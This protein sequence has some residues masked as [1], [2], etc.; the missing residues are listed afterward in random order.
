MQ[1]DLYTRSTYARVYTV[2]D[3]LNELL[4]HGLAVE[5]KHYS[6]VLKG[7]ICDAPAKAMIKC[8]KQFSG[9]YACDCCYQKCIWLHKVTYQEVTT[10]HLR[11]DHEFCIQAQ[12]QHHH[13]I[14]PFCRLP[15][16]MIKIFPNDY[17]HQSCLRLYEKAFTYLDERSKKNNRM[18]AQHVAQISSK[19]IQLRSSI[20]TAFAHQPKDLESVD[21]WRAT[22][23]RQFLL[24][25]GKIVLKKILKQDLYEH[26]M[27]FSVALA[28][29]VCP[30]L[31]KIYKN[32]AKEL[33]QYFVLQAENFMDQNF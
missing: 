15:V 1:I 26:F 17:M 8:I 25:T 31:A 23:Y 13:A 18:P 7:I 6:V 33:L 19:M 12:E 27:T 3:D 30:N 22:K 10:L 24:Y 28:I 2:I 5:D 16:D 21:R 11:T 32:Y 4:S 20:P 9:Y 14:S 29:L